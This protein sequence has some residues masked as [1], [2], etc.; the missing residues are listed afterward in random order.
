MVGK[1][2]ADMGRVSPMLWSASCAMAAA[3]RG[4]RYQGGPYALYSAVAATL[5]EGY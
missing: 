1:L 4:C 3:V 2:R 5:I